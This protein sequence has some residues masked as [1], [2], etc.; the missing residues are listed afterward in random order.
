MNLDKI[1]EMP[2]I[3]NNTHESIYRVFHVLEYVLDM[4]DRGDSKETILEV[5]DFLKKYN[6]NIKL[7]KM[8]G[9]EDLLTLQGAVELNDWSDGRKQAIK[10]IVDKL[11]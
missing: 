9:V 10:D 6:Q 11:K 1:I 8:F 4:V 7:D 2:T 3:Y 5:A